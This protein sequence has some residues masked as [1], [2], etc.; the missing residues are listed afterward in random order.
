MWGVQRPRWGFVV[1]LSVI[2]ALCCIIGPVAARG[3]A[4]ALPSALP[5]LVVYDNALQNGFAD[6]SLGLTAV[7]LCARN[8]YASGPCGI[9]ASFAPLVGMLDFETATPFSTAP[10]AAFEFNYGAE[11]GYIANFEVRLVG[12][13]GDTLGKVRLGEVNLAPGTAP[14]FQHV[15]VPM[16]G[17]NPTNATARGI[18]LV[19]TGG[20]LT[21]IGFDDLQFSVA[22]PL[23]CPNDQFVAQYFATPDLSGSAAL[24]R[25][26]ATIDH[27]WGYDGPGSVVPTDNFSA[28]WQGRFSLAAGTY[29]F[30]AVADDGIRVT[31]D[32]ATLIDSW[33]DQRSTTY[34]ASR[35]LSA[36]AHDIVVE[37]YERDGV[38]LV[39]LSWSAA[40]ITATPTAS[41]TPT[42]APASPTPPATPPTTG[43]GYT[44]TQALPPCPSGQWQTTLDTANLSF[45]VVCKP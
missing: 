16:S 14:G 4:N 22:T 12:G 25:C 24:V 33:R 8:R 39:H 36:G 32:G 30:T 40:S 43:G 44:I 21:G 29:A 7:D 15:T 17:L 42:V 6:R 26:E 11:P 31:V 20:A 9:V 18:Q 10:Y 41:A 19:N 38:A 3:S 23:P 45:T 1:A 5:P 37:Y 34:T 2:V 35:A 13:T 27:D 28:R